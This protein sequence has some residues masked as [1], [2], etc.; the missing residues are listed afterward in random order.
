MQTYTDPVKDIDFSLLLGKIVLCRK[1]NGKE[2]VS[3]LFAINGD[4]L[5][6]RT[7]RGNLIVNFASEIVYAVEV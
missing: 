6:F 5:T 7:R 4:E 1:S 3:M 2:F